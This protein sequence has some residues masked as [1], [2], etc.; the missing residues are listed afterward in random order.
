[1]IEFDDADAEVR[2]ATGFYIDEVQAVPGAELVLEYD[3][4]DA[5]ELA[6]Y[7]RI[8]ADVTAALVSAGLDE[9]VPLLESNLFGVQLDPRVS[10]DVQE[11]VD[12]LL[13][14]GTPTAVFVLPPG[15]D[16]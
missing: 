4:R 8:E 5:A 11:H 9:L 3:P 15:A 2:L 12:R 16:R 10:T 1:V 14:L 6:E 7:E 13:E